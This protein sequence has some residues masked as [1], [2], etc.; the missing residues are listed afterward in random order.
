MREKG[1]RW[2]ISTLIFGLGAHMLAN[3]ATFYEQ[4]LLLF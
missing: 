1:R 2:N 4:L 3:W